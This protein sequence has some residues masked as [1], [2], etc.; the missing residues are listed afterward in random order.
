MTA[1]AWLLTTWGRIRE[2]L[3]PELFALRNDL[4]QAKA[5]LENA[6]AVL[7]GERQLKR[8]AQ[9]RATELSVRLTQQAR[10]IK[11]ARAAVKKAR[12]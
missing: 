8:E 3:Q 1:H 10:E 5:E 6:R 7:I 12:K 2:T 11:A 4:R 9:R